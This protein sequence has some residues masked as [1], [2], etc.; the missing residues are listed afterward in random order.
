[1]HDI[2]I[3]TAVEEET[4]MDHYKAFKDYILDTRAASQKKMPDRER[5]PHPASLGPVLLGTK[6]EQEGFSVGFIDNILISP[7]HREILHRWLRQNPLAVALSTTH[8]Y[9]EG[10]IRE[11][12]DEFRKESPH[13]W[14]ILGGQT[15]T[16]FPE[17]ASLADVT[18][19]GEAEQSIVK[20]M[21]AIKHHG[22][23]QEIG[24]IVYKENGALKKTSD[25]EPLDFE[26]R[27][28]LFPDWSL[29][30]HRPGECYFVETVRGCPHRCRFC[31][32]T[33]IF[34]G[35]V[36]YRDPHHVVEELKR[37]YEQYGINL[38]RIV[39]SCFTSP[40][41]RCEEI[42]NLIVREN[43]D[44]QWSCF[45]RVDH[46]TSSLAHAMKEAGCFAVFFGIESGDDRMLKAMGKGFK[47]SQILPG[48]ARATDAG[49]IT[50][51]SFLVGF[52]GDTAESVERTWQVIKDSNLDLVLLSVFWLN[53][54]CHVYFNKE[55]YQIEGEGVHW[56][57]STMTS[58][59]AE[60]YV[61]DLFTRIIDLD[62]PVPGSE[63]FF[64]KLMSV[65]ISAR[66]VVDLFRGIKSIHRFQQVGLQGMSN[67]KNGGSFLEADMMSLQDAIGRMRS[68]AV[69]L[70]KNTHE[71]WIDHP[72]LD[73]AV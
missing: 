54:Q 29:A 5:V 52:P 13:V 23:L 21:H 65:G 61:E 56:K 58:E 27:A 11:L 31:A 6:L 41:D 37:N 4:G 15:V 63:L 28:P 73:Y 30:H 36:R 69:E 43:L 66:E 35:G 71:Y 10:V 14:T 9:S 46:M 2:I 44:L 70:R 19:F 55:Q 67:L 16:K 45:G 22:S 26:G 62:K 17:L 38:Y 34:P 8:L 72:I 64:P 1:M 47:S 39:D 50:H 33:K 7:K 68:M 25:P 20:V 51:G 18:V 59:E 40:P 12:L 24:G 3:V 48:I 42:C 49:I 60:R 32:Y 53:K 57:H